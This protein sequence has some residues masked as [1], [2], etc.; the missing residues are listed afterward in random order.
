MIFTCQS[1]Y[2]GTIGLLYYVIAFVIL[3]LDQASKWMIV[4][5]MQLHESRP[6]IG[7][8]FQIT[9]HR[10]R[11]AAFGI[12]QDQRS[13]FIIIT[14]VIVIALIWYLNKSIKDKRKLLPLALS[15]LIGGAIGNF[16]DRVRFGEVVDFLQF[17]FQFRFFGNDVDYTYPIFNLADSA[18]VLGVAFIVIDTWIGWRQEKRGMMQ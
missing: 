5:H 18:I 17:R 8:F 1:A 11:G 3:V 14:I 4:T 7:Q 6:V 9:S 10:N 13:F 12:L 16:I 15:F 2:G